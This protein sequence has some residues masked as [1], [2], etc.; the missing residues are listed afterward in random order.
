MEELLEV[1]YDVGVQLGLGHPNQYEEP[2][3]LQ[4]RREQV[5]L[6]DRDEAQIKEAS[7]Q[8][9]TQIERAWRD[10]SSRAQQ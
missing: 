5:R 6:L 8:L 9:T 2:L 4:L 10:F 7:R 1:A 3:A